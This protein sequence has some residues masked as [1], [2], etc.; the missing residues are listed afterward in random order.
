MTGNQDADIDWYE[1]SLPDPSPATYQAVDITISGDATAN[2]SLVLRVVVY[3]SDHHAVLTRDFS[4]G[5]EAY[6]N[7][8]RARSGAYYVS[9]T[10]LNPGKLDQSANYRILLQPGDLTDN[11]DNTENDAVSLA[12]G[13]PAG[14]SIGYQ[15]D[16]D[17]YQMTVD[18]ASPHIVGVELTSDSSVVDY[19]LS[20]W[21]GT[22]LIRKVSD[23]DGSDGPT[24]LKTAVYVPA[25]M[26]GSAVYTF[27]VG[28]AQNDEG[29][30]V[31]YTI[32][33]TETAVPVAVSGINEMNAGDVLRYYDERNEQSET[34][35]SYTPAKLEVFSGY[36]PTFSAN[37][38]WLDFRSDP[39][40]D[41]VDLS[42]PG[43]GTTV[44]TFPWIAGYIDYQGDRDM[45]QLDFGKLSPGGSETEW[46]YDVKV[47]MV[48]PFPG[49][50]VEY[51]W[52]LYR[53]RNRNGVIMDDPTSPD[54]YKACAGDTTPRERSAMD[55]TV[56][57]GNDTFW[58][59]SDWGENAKFYFGVSDFDY[60]Y[61]PDSGNPPEENPEPDD[62]WGY[63]APYYF[64][65]QL[66]YHP[67]LAGPE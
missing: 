46:Y 50:T 37:T 16:V 43:D 3:D 25:D 28:D 66:I 61:L 6:Q 49:S 27:K 62:D 57:T 1:F 51:V 22:Q 18:T 58:I 44:I 67:G 7:R 45:F 64:Q 52:K 26:N 30:D 10:P 2:A 59:G 29:S 65:L 39:L 53:D 32:T 41:G 48:V 23:L 35:G 54:G 40:P 9:V 34:G 47:R 63:D 36:Q 12:S 11:D 56:P 31:A 38:D 55:L 24:H 20:I 42:D 19:Q 15:A 33:A 8:F 14:G 17:W 13:V 4:C 5:G 60:K 21:R